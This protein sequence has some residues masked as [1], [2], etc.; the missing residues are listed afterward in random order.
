MQALNKQQLKNLE[1]EHS[2]YVLINVL[3]RDMFNE[4]HIPGSINIPVNDDNFEAKVE[5]IAGSKDRDIVVYCAKT[6]CTASPQ[7]AEKLEK[8]GFIHISDYE[9]GMTDWFGE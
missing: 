5:D 8:A 6:E 4:K 9:G 1:A 2:D 7:A 3:P